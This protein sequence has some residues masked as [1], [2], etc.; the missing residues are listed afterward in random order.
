MRGAQNPGYGVSKGSQVSKVSLKEVILNQFIH[1][2]RNTV[3]EEG[4]GEN[5]DTRIR[6]FKRK[7]C[8]IFWEEQVISH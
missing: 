2:M 4:R 8:G 3:D 5:W 7:T 6:M 1:L